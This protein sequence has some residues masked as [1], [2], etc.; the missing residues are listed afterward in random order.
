MKIMIVDDAVFIRKVLKGILIELGHEVIAEASNGK[1]A[2]SLLERVKPEVITLDITLPDMSGL[3]ILKEIK[4]ISPQTQVIMIS[5]LSGQES[6][7]EALREGAADYITKPFSKEKV[8]KVLSEIK[9]NV[10]KMVSTQNLEQGSNNVT[11]FKEF[12]VDTQYES[13]EVY[14]SH[15][16]EEINNIVGQEEDE[17]E[18]AQVEPESDN[19]SIEPMEKKAD[20]FEYQSDE[21]EREVEESVVSFNKELFQDIH[22][23]SFFENEKRAYLEDVRVYEESI[24]YV[25][26]LHFNQ[27]VTYSF[28]K[29]KIGNGF[30]VNIE[31]CR[32][33]PHI[34]EVMRF[35]N[36]SVEEI[37]IE[38]ISGN[39][40]IA[41][42]TMIKKFNIRENEDIIEIVLQKGSSRV[43]YNPISK[44]ILIENVEKRHI[45]VEKIEGHLKI[46]ILNKDI[47]MEEGK[48]ILN[49]DVVETIEVVRDF[50]GYSIMIKTAKDVDYE[51][52]ESRNSVGLRLKESNV[53]KW[54]NVY[55]QED[56][57]I[58]DILPS[59]SDFRVNIE[60]D[61]ENKK[62]YLYLQ[63]I[64]LPQELKEKKFEYEKGFIESIEFTYDEDKKQSMLIVQ[65]PVSRVNVSKENGRILLICRANRAFLLYDNLQKRIIFQ[66]IKPSD[67]DLE[68]ED[69]RILYFKIFN[70]FIVLIKDSMV[71]EN[72]LIEK[73][74]MQQV[75]GGYEGK[76]LL[77][78]R[79]SFYSLLAKDRVSTEIYLTPI[80]AKNKI[81]FFEYEESEGKAILHLSGEGV[82]DRNVTELKDRTGIGVEVS[83]CVLENINA[84]SM[85]FED[86]SIEK[87]VFE[88]VDDEKVIVKVYTP[89]NEYEILDKT[90]G[91]DIV[92][93]LKKVEVIFETN[94][95]EIVGVGKDSV[96]F[97][98]DKENN[99]VEIRIK[100]KGVYIPTGLFKVEDGV[101]RSYQIF[102]A[103]HGYSILVKL[104]KKASVSFSDK[105]DNIIV[106]NFIKYPELL[107]FELSNISDKE[108]WLKIGFD[109]PIF[110]RPSIEYVDQTLVEIELKKVN[111]ENLDLTSKKYEEGI[112]KNVEF[113]PYEDDLK[114]RIGYAFSHLNLEVVENQVILK[115]EKVDT[116]IE[117][118]ADRIT[119]NYI[120]PE[121]ISYRVFDENGVIIMEI[122]FD[123]G[124]LENTIPAIKS[125]KSVKYI[126]IETS[127]TGWRIYI[128]TNLEMYYTFEKFE[129]NFFIK[130][131]KNFEKSS[132]SEIA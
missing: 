18:S 13:Q 121:Q 72:E 90:N 38:E 103:K 68:L 70:R 102:K 74:Q 46:N 15:K 33:S 60:H 28:G 37:R 80:K 104:Q 86:S 30:I 14:E 69:D 82:F 41:I 23:P 122:P 9:I 87:L 128:I 109:E 84:G 93:Y 47:F 65:T 61:K 113:L 66:N 42:K 94:I 85:V 11:E 45:H 97:V 39:V 62:V 29:M 35:E 25:L 89:V 31:N 7:I 12:T 51:I 108:T 3:E 101:L 48:N 73:V 83:D 44:L 124:Y 56:M 76:I 98:I 50:K 79:C 16:I 43:S 127:N 107:F 4:K 64:S 99:Q 27:S 21:R 110:E 91:F 24:G 49:D 125:E 52:I 67:I 126:N 26:S 6:V 19:Y 96:D 63:D 111:Y 100:E 20:A 54:W 95:F 92:F 8:E 117:A 112:I 71:E 81:N 10:D 17:M 116:K 78:K 58:L 123:A 75:E 119:F 114:I 132:V 115:F 2:I 22:K 36:G 34:K 40:Y 5:A 59:M 57:T 53:I 118:D 106:L 131:Q 105:E 129:D 32:L 55:D 88:E 130:L 120:N 77:K 1:D